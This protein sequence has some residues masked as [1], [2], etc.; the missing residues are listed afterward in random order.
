MNTLIDSIFKDTEN[1]CWYG[2]TEVKTKLHHLG[3][4]KL[5]NDG[6][7]G[8]HCRLAKCKGR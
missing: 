5:R 7:S 2:K 8:D 6:T 3:I 4:R 1:Q